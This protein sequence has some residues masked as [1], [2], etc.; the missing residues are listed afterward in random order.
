MLSLAG[1]SVLLDSIDMRLD[2][3]LGRGNLDTVDLL[4]VK[5]GGVHCESLRA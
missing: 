1:G 3:K 5:G 4:V 2:R